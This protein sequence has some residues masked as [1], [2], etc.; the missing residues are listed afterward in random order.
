[1]I[2]V[3][4]LNDQFSREK[5]EELIAQVEMAK[6]QRETLFYPLSVWEFEFL[7]HNECFRI[8]DGVLLYCGC[9]VGIIGNDTKK[10]DRFLHMAE[11]LIGEEQTLWK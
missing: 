9:E 10:I 6:P 4:I 5:L 7:C 1:M 3:M 8:E 2:E 11:K